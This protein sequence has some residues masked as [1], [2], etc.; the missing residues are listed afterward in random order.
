MNGREA[1]RTLQGIVIVGGLAREHFEG[2]LAHELGHVWLF[3][4]RLDQLPAPLTEG[5]CEL[6]RHA[7]L[8]RLGT[9]LAG[10]LR[11]RL[12]EGTDPVYGDGF[13]RVKERWDDGRTSGVLGLLGQ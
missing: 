13:R 10:E 3:R 12:E 4:A 8:L 6:V 2:V 1:S 7:W 5:F 11:R 9:P